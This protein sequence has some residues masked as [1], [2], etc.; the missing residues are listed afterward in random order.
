MR[1]LILFALFFSIPV[2]AQQPPPT[3]QYTP[4][5]VSWTQDGAYTIIYLGDNKQAITSPVTIGLNCAPNINC[6]DVVG[7]DYSWTGQSP[8]QLRHTI[9]PGDTAATIF[10]D[11]A[12]QFKNNPTIKAAIGADIVEYAHVRANVF[13]FFQSYPFVDD[14]SPSLS[15]VL[16]MQYVPGDGALEVNPVVVC[17]RQQPSGRQARAGDALCGIYFSA[18]SPAGSMDAKNVHPML[19]Q[20]IARWIDP[21]TGKI[22]LSFSSFDTVSFNVPNVIVNGQRLNTQAFSAICRV[23]LAADQSGLPSSIDPENSS[24]YQRINFADV[25]S[26]IGCPGNLFEFSNNQ[27][28]P[29]IGGAYRI[30]AAGSLKGNIT[31]AQLR[32]CKNGTDCLYAAGPSASRYNEVILNRSDV[33]RFNGTTDA[34]TTDAWAAL[35]S[36]TFAI[37]AGSGLTSLSIERIAP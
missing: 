11:I 19:G 22:A 1:T 2:F 23:F 6:P 37:K 29:K 31:E 30:S 13:Q 25:D 18:D 10:A 5:G 26:S 9:V 28:T 35:S 20:I 27:I 16:G 32:F 15:G 33:M 3:G 8:I 14:F 4:P 24:P 36:G 17:Y 21:A 7:F 34:L 12:A